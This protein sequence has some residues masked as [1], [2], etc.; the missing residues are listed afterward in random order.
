MAKGAC[1]AR[2]EC[3]EGHAV[4]RDFAGELSEPAITSP[5]RCFSDGKVGC[6]N[7]SSAK[8]DF[9]AD[10]EHTGFGIQGEG[11]FA[12]EVA[13]Y[14]RVQSTNILAPGCKQNEVIHVADVMA[15]PYPVLEKMVEL[16]KID[17]GEKLACESANRKAPNPVAVDDSVDEAEGFSVSDRAPDDLFKNG[18]IDRG[19]V[20]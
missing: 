10:V 9:V 13:R 7:A 20:P 8:L 2:L 11:E 1:E 19:E 4:K 17:I 12:F 3:G 18:M 16:V 14:F 15:H 6:P 5:E